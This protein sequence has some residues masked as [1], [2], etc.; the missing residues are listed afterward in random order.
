MRYQICWQVATRYVHTSVSELLGK[1]T[2]QLGNLHLAKTISMLRLQPWLKNKCRQ[3][4]FWQLCQ[5][6]ALKASVDFQIYQGYSWCHLDELNNFPI[7]QEVSATIFGETW[8][9]FGEHELAVPYSCIIIKNG[10][11]FLRG[12]AWRLCSIGG[13]G[14]GAKNWIVPPPPKVPERVTS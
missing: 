11:G 12:L 13:W 6:C 5:Y 3:Q 4:Y 8:K 14:E 7:N 2:I 1:Q 9:L 10:E